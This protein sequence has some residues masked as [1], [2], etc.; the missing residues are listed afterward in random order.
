MSISWFMLP[1]LTFSVYRC[2][3]LI[4]W[5]HISYLNRHSTVAAVLLP[6]NGTSVD[7]L[8]KTLRCCWIL[9]HWHW[10]RRSYFSLGYLVILFSYKCCSTVYELDGPGIESRWGEI[11]RT[12]PDRPW[13]P[14]SL[15]YNGYRVFPGSKVL[16]GRNAD[17]SPPSSA[18]V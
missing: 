15:L 2:I 10:K 7:T 14:H 4:L 3:C 11:F 13:D 12:C 1:T 16:P 8:Q 17:P 9:T 5:K 18:E 6:F